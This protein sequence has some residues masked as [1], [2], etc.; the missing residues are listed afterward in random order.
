MNITMLECKIEQKMTNPSMHHPFQKEQFFFLFNSIEC[1]PI[2]IF[3]K[4][5]TLKK[6]AFHPT[7]Y[8]KN[9]RILYQDT[10]DFTQVLQPRKHFLDHFIG[11]IQK[12]PF[13]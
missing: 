1:R 10:L 13:L 9:S 2:T 5:I 7:N 11:A 4:N 6:I 8:E 12:M 3:L